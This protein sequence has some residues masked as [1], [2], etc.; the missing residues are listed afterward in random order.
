[1][2]TKTVGTALASLIGVLSLGFVEE[3][4]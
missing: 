1:M 3:G 2:K 4:F